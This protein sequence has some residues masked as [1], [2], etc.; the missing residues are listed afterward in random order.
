MK[1]RKIDP[2][3]LIAIG[4]LI[5]SF[6][7]LFVYIKQANI[8]SKQTD[9]LLEQT[10]ANAWPRLDVGLNIGFDRDDSPLFLN[11]EIH[12]KGTGPAIIEGVRV[13]YEDQ[14]TIDWWDLFKKSKLPDSIDDGIANRDIYNSVVSANEEFYWA[15]LQEDRNLA[16][17]VFERKDKINI[18]ICYKSVFDDY[19]LLTK[20]LGGD[21]KIEKLE[22]KASPIPKNQEFKR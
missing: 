22:T 11:I 5:A 1:K 13:L 4:V 8:M 2:N 19:W 20:R 21:T 16:A 9:I 12:N 17:W 14:H 10:K 3:L 7:A 18:E 15:Q 6:S